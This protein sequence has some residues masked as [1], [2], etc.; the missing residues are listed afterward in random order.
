MKKIFALVFLVSIT[1]FIHAQEGVVFKILIKPN[2]TYVS[3]MRAHTIY[4]TVFNTGEALPNSMDNRS[5]IES[6]IKMKSILVAKAP[7]ENGNIPI[8]MRYE[9]A[10]STTL[11]NGKEQSMPLPLPDTAIKAYYTPDNQIIMDTIIGESFNPQIKGMISNILEHI[12]QQIDFPETPMQ[13]G[14]QF[15]TEKP[16]EMPVPGMKPMETQIRSAYTLNEIKGGKAYFTF[17]QEI[18]LETE[19]EGFSMQ[20]RGS[21]TGSCEYDIDGHFLSYFKNELPMQITTNMNENMSSIMST[22]TISE[23]KTSIK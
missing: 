17:Q 11:I 2:T 3:E 15:T 10:S 5:L 20:A 18:S 12:G 1:S 23:L 16:M 14:D 7:K 13:V 8:S 19:Q 6:T 4:E 9:D 21:G 22:T